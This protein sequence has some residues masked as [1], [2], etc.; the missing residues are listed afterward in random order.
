MERQTISVLGDGIYTIAV[1]LEA[2]HLSNHPATLAYVEAPR[3]APNA[4]LLLLACVVA[5]GYPGAWSCSARSPAARRRRRH[6]RFNGRA[7]P[8]VTADRAQRCCAR[9]QAD[10]V[11]VISPRLPDPRHQSALLC[12]M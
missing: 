12:A 8:D 6:G 1:A 2:L 5:T 3:V 7:R 11:A 10:G 9:D 4:L